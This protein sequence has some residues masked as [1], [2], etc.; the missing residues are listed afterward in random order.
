MRIF[1]CEKNYIIL[2]T[3]NG[4]I[5]VYEEK[6]LTKICYYDHVK[7]E[8]EGKHKHQPTMTIDSDEFETYLEVKESESKW[9]RNE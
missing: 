4:H 2:H 6:G 9:L 3:P 1:R 5:H 7:I 8:I